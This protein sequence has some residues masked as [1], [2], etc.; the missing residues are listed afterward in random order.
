MKK[1]T[2]IYVV[3]A[4]VAAVVLLGWAFAPRPLEVEVARVTQGHF[5]TTIDEDAKTRLRD[6]Y[7]VSAPLSGRLGRIGLREGDAVTTDALVATLTPVLPAMQDDRTLREQQLRVEITEAQARRA[8]ARAEG[9]KVALLQA[10]NELRR[11]EQLAKQGFIAPTK[12]EADRLGALAAQKELD[13]AEQERHVAG[14]E[15]EQAQAAL[16]AV[17]GS[18]LSG[19]RGFAV[20]A[21]IAGRILRIAQASETVVTLGTP[22]LEV[23]DTRSL[24][25]VVELLTSDALQAVPGARVLIERW[26]GSAPLEG[27]VRLVEPSAFT[28]VSALGVEE[29]RV[30]VLIDITSP[31]AQWAALGDGFRVGVRIVTMA[32]DNAVKVPASAIFPL[33]QGLDDAVA[34]MG[35]FVVAD[36]VARLVS[37]EIGARSA[38]DAW[39]RRGLAPG[40]TVIVYPPPALKDGVRVRQRSV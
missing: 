20:R 9:A 21:P 15:V 24:E 16:M 38:T 29:Q 32:V 12:L 40:A 5:E 37:V 28:K 19:S 11:S 31:S 6:R 25:V 14:H 26:G 36:G 2:W 10:G 22:L 23:G 4:G 7:I 3:V 13:A 27:R 30:K 17:R 39:V 1:R 33:P 34:G 8:V 35:A 18:G